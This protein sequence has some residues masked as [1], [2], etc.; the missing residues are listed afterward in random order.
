M[1]WLEEAV[2]V[3]AWL[4]TAAWV[5]LWFKCRA[6]IEERDDAE[7]AYYRLVAKINAKAWGAKDETP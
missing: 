6:A 4:V 5:G 2:W 1:G 7:D 3:Y